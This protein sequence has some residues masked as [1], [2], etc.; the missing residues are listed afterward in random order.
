MLHGTVTALR[1]E[2]ILLFTVS[3]MLGTDFGLLMKST[4]VEDAM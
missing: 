2:T 3:L 1:E 4:F